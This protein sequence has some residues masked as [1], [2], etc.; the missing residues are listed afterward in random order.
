MVAVDKAETDFEEHVAQTQADTE[1]AQEVAKEQ[2]AKDEAARRQQQALLDSQ[3]EDLTAREQALAAMLRGKDEETGKIVTQRTQELEQKHKDALDAMALDHASKVEKLERDG[4]KKEILELTEERDTGNRTL[5]DSQV[6]IS[7]KAKLLFEANDSINDQ[8][9]KLDG[10]EGTL[11]EA[12]AH[13]ETLN[14]ALEDERQLKKD[15]AAA[16]KDYVA[17]VNL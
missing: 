1:K 11:S 15:D 6:V 12:G 9:L 8:K 16:H 2:A 7:D 13:E 3:E 17:S 4:L 10:L 5:A 14:K